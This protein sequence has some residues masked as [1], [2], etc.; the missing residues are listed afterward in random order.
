M[1]QPG[2]NSSGS[3][4]APMLCSICIPVYN[5]EDCLPVFLDS[6]FATLA[7]YQKVKGIDFEVLAVD[8]SSED[9]SLEILRCYSERHKKLKVFAFEQNSGHQA[10][11]LCGLNHAKGDII[12][13]MDS[14]GQD[15]P[16]SISDLVDA[17]IDSK[18]EIILAKRKSR[19]DGLAKK[20]TAWLFYRSLTL[21]GLPLESRDAGDYRLVT[22]RIKDLILAQPN[23]LQY[24]RGQ[25]FTLKAPTRYI[26][27]DR[28]ERIA[29]KTKYT[30]SKM[31]RLAISSAFVIDPLKVA[32][33]YIMIAALF[34]ATSGITAIAFLGIKVAFPT[35]Y[36]S[37][38]TTLAILLLLLFSIVISMI[39]FQSLYVSL[40]FR[41]L[42]NEPAYLEK[43]F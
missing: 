8:D 33:V 16:E 13:T 35:Y 40:L 42:R 39:A 1:R 19:K 32:Q 17:F 41:S 28:K 43:R 20:A 14:D 26:C 38:I 37:G 27:I 7:S 31:T 3:I 10:A 23:S 30:L 12:I 5:E 6:L 34:T 24:I 29:G 4:S 2:E 18:H 36:A 22:K 9:K 11:I 25:I 21:F 15:P